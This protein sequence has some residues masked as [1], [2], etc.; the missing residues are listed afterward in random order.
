[1]I[2]EA[3]GIWF[4]Q[5]VYTAQLLKA[6][7]MTECKPVATP[8]DKDT[9]LLKAKE[10]DECIDQNEYQA[11]VGGLL[12][13][14]TKTRPDISFAVGN[15]AR[16]CSH[17]TQVHWTAIKRIMRELKILESS[18]LEITSNRNASDTP[19]Q[20]GVEAE[21]LRLDTCSSGVED[22]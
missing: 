22:Q 17:P 19:T 21:N 18:S 9:S 20:I 1:M 13:L 2:Q 14:S 7:G 6:F 10:G 11:A 5:P 8:S 16:F 12:Y 15:V 4:G 3:G